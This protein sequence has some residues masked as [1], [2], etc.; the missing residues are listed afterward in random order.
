MSVIIGPWP[1][2][3]EIHHQVVL[4]R[5]RQGA[6]RWRQHPSR[7]QPTV[8][9]QKSTAADVHKDVGPRRQPPPSLQ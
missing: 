8:N 4:D 9:G 7:Q 2:G 3:A 5:N 1:P 6:L